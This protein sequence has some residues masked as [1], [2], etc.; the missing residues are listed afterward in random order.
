[1]VE[2]RHLTIEE[3]SLAVGIFQVGMRQIEAV[4]VK[5]VEVSQSVSMEPF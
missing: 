1:M 4:V 2:Q 3:I 5:V